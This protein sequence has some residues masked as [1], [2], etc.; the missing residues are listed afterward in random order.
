M[1]KNYIITILCFFALLAVS[2]GGGDTTGDDLESKKASLAEKKSAL[3]ELQVEIDELRAE[4]LVLD[5]PKEKALILIKTKTLTPVTFQRYTD[6]QASLMSDDMVFASSE[7]GGRII[8]LNVKEGQFVNKGSL[9]ARLD[10]KSV[11]DQKAELETSIAFAKDVFDRQSRLWDQKIGTEVQ[12]LQAKNNFDRLE[13]SMEMLKTQLSKARV[14]APISGVVDKEFL[15]PGEIAAPG[16]PIVQLFNPNKLKVTADV[17]ESYL[18]KIKR[19]DRVNVKYP[20]L[21]IETS[22]TVSL[23]GRTIDPSNR[24]FKVE[25]NTDNVAGK[26]K[27]N[28]LAEISFNDFTKADA[29]TVELPLVQEEVNGRKYIYVVAD[30]GGKAIAKKAY[31]TI[32]ESHMGEVIIES[33]L[34]AGDKIITDGARSVSEG[35][36]VKELNN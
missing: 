17:P 35:S 2:C 31:V 19:G 13:K 23:V 18:G 25:V 7:L 33:G 34:V 8:S 11:E 29:I 4:I 10:L 5:P 21:D 16:S 3:K 24:T 36:A 32:G 6:V 28:L 12:Y 27:P 20:A 9:I 26:L 30:Q 15:Q 14:Y 22:K 1:N